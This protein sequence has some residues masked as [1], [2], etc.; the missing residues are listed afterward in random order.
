MGS[1][2]EKDLMINEDLMSMNPNIKDKKLLNESSTIQQEAPIVQQESSTIQQEAPIVQQEPND[3]KEIN[4]WTPIIKRSHV[5]YRRSYIPEWIDEKEVMYWNCKLLDY[6]PSDE[7][8]VENMNYLL[9]YVELTIGFE[10]KLSITLLLFDYILE[11]IYTIKNFTEFRRVARKKLLDLIIKHHTIRSFENVYRLIFKDEDDKSALDVALKQRHEQ[12][13]EELKVMVKYDEQKM[14]NEQK[15]DDNVNDNDEK[16]V[17]TEGTN[18]VDD[19][20][21]C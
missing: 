12:K 6:L 2:L 1:N 15:F 20:K 19:D 16:D 21:R 5:T 10:K 8:S 18:D 13:N 7:D 11:D 17:N 14:D 4:S 9:D 3:D